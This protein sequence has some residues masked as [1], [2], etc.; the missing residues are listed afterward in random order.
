M[1]SSDSNISHYVII[2]KFLDSIYNMGTNILILET[3]LNTQ[4]FSAYSRCEIS[5][6][7]FDTKCM[8]LRLY[9]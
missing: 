2:R 8:T 1:S 3:L 6:E 9:L 5:S 4:D 7:M